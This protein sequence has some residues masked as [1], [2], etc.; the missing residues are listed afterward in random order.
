MLR[1]RKIRVIVRPNL[2]VAESFW[3]F[4]YFYLNK[5]RVITFPFIGTA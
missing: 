4:D 2:N 3:T 5:R 1:N